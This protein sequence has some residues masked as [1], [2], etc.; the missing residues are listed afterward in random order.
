MAPA[1]QN[2]AEKRRV[3]PSSA[4]TQSGAQP[5]RTFNLK[6][7]ALGYFFI[8]LVCV[9]WIAASF[10]VSRLEAHGLSPVLLTY[11]CSSGFIILTPFRARAI[12]DALSHARTGKG[13]VHAKERGD[14]TNRK[15]VSTGVNPRAEV[16]TR[17]R[18]SDIDGIELATLVKDNRTGDE[19]TGN[20]RSA[21]DK[22][23]RV[24]AAY[25]APYSFWYHARA[26]LAVA[27][28]WVAAQ[29]A[30]DYSLLM[31]S[32][33]ANSMLSSSSAV[34]TFAVSVYLGLDKFSWWKVIAVSSYVIGTV[35]V[36]LADSDPRGVET[37]ENNPMSGLDVDGSNALGESIQTPMIG[38]ILAL[39]AAGMYALYTAIMKVYLVEDER[40][41]MTLFFGLMGVI[42]F[43]V[44]G[45]G[46]VVLRSLGFLG[47]L[48]RSVDTRVFLLACS[49]AFFDNVCSDYLWARAVLLTSPTIASIG[50]SLQI[51]MAASV[52]VIIGHPIWATHLKQACLMALG[53][54]FILAGFF[55][56]S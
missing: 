3:P 27:P 14:E 40:T 23:D 10:L 51:P 21:D 36:T 45:V 46:L 9:I 6:G 35:L 37:E 2:T 39:A 30:F 16:R 15:G 49:K 31:T 8:F 32:V 24:R 18:D 43:T 33:T 42:N 48:F 54:V 19:E 13:V 34:F 53:T 52:E 12:F 56:V 26:A 1:P 7:E 50:L 44:M 11:I 55:G 5:S 41:D 20:S 47:N 4:K 22:E 38:N 28:I 25:V 17:R 29:L